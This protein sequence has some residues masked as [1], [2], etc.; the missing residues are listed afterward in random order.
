MC[1]NWAGVCIARLNPQPKLEFGLVSF[2]SVCVMVRG[3]GLA[4]F[5]P[6]AP[7]LLLLFFF[8]IIIIIIVG[9]DN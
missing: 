3:S 1:F 5:R 4:D 2:L 6:A 7:L 8:I 9:N